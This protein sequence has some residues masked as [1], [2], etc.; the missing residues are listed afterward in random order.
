MVG[1]IEVTFPR[2][3]G[4]DY[5]VTSPPDDVYNCIAWAAGHIDAWWW[6]VGSGD[7]Y[8]PEAAPREATIEAFRV[9][10]ITLGY[11]E[12]ASENLETGY[13]K[14][15][16]FAHAQGRPTHAARQLPNGRWTSELGRRE[17]IE[18]ALHDLGG[19]LYGT[20]V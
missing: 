10:F 15:A 1:G 16:L 11:T 6:P 2:L 7:I 4:A 3:H 12:C 5:Q 13:E 17:D 20:V 18:H 14:V 9:A 8:W 19:D